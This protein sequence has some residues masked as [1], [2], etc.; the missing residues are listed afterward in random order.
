MVENNLAY[1]DYGKKKN[2]SSELF[3]WNIAG[4]PLHNYQ[5]KVTGGTYTSSSGRYILDLTRMSTEGIF[6]IDTNFGRIANSYTRELF[7]SLELQDWKL[8]GVKVSLV[9]LNLALFL[10]VLF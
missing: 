10:N 3:C 6:I 9:I 7:V 8:V 5:T 1:D 4:C 2:D